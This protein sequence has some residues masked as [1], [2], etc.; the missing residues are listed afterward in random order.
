MARRIDQQR[1][2]LERF[3]FVLNSLKKK[4]KG[5][6]ALCAELNV[7]YDTIKTTMK[8]MIGLGLVKAVDPVERAMPTVF[9]AIKNDC[10]RRVI[11]MDDPARLSIQ[12]EI[13][14]S[15]TLRKT[16]HG[17]QSGMQQFAGAE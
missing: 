9:H 13:M 3:E 7:C 15:Q 1:K 14:Q 4:P 2:K 8:E 10:G 11:R 16:G 12:K 5:Y 6:Y 17:I